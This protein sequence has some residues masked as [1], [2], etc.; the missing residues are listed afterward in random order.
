M[1]SINKIIWPINSHHMNK[2][3]KRDMKLSR[4]I[5]NNIVRQRNATQT[6]ARKIRHGKVSREYMANWLQTCRIIVGNFLP[7]HRGCQS[8]VIFISSSLVCELVFS[9][10]CTPSFLFIF[11]RLCLLPAYLRSVYCILTR[12]NFCLWHQLTISLR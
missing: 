5:A 12:F 7:L 9:F 11:F 6:N 10:S 4:L 2:K 3:W 1:F 8:L